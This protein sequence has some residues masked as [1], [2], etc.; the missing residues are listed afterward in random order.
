MGNP[1]KRKYNMKRLVIIVEGET[2]EAFVHQIL[3][4]YIWACGFTTPIQCFKIKH[5]GGGVSKYSHIEKDILATVHEKDVVVT[6]MIDF[7]GLPTDTPSFKESISCPKPIERVKMIENSILEEITRKTRA[8][9][10][11][12]PCIQLHEIEA[13]IFS[14]NKGFYELF[15]KNEADLKKLDDIILDFPNPED[16]DNGPNTAPSKRLKKA[17]R[18]YDKVLYGIEL[19]KNIG[20]ETILSKCPHF[21]EWID[22]LKKELSNT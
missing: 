7:Y 20:I 16:I 11:F 18:G 19:M 5:S 22:I 4:P 6:T 2:E 14:S 9:I 17:I 3:A 12:F 15:E 10:V 13:L 1:N 8:S 21:K